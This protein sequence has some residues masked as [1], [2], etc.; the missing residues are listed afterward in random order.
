MES[1]EEM[2]VKMAEIKLQV[3][4][5]EFGK[6]NIEYIK[7]IKQLKDRLEEKNK[8]QNKLEGELMNLRK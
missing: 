7:N 8:K 5:K 4:E 2:K 6:A 3:M 1:I